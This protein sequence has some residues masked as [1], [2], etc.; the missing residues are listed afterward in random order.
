MSEYLK[1]S[2]KTNYIASMISF[3]AVAFS[4][5]ANQ[6]TSFNQNIAIAFGLMTGISAIISIQL[7]Q[8]DKQ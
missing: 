5:L 2:A 6:V 8:G 7:L 3:G 4:S 1:A